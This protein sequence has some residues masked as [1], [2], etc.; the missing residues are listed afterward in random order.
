MK[1]SV[2]KGITKSYV[3]AVKVPTINSIQKPSNPRPLKDNFG[4]AF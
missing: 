4:G 2:Y 1:K 3:G